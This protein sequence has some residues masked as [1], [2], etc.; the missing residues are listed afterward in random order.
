MPSVAVGVPFTKLV[1][2]FQPLY[3]QS[4]ERFIS[5]TEVIVGISYPLPLPSEQRNEHLLALVGYGQT[6]MSGSC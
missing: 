4:L 5:R 3:Y 1:V 6:T 2:N